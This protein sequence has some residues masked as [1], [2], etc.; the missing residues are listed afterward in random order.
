MLS[1]KKNPP[2]HDSYLYLE[3]GNR[4][5]ICICTEGNT[6]QAPISFVFGRC[7]FFMIYDDKK[8][9]VEWVE[10]PAQSETHAAGLG[11]AQSILNF[12]IDV[13]I[14]NQPGLKAM[15]VFE[16]STVQIYLAQGKTVEEALAL[17]KEKN[18]QKSDCF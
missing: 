11:A 16:K 3:V 10:N 6:L 2:Q 15:Q 4:M 14:S 17:F 12:N 18:S 8:Q 7:P 9:S 13:L 1:R 5:K